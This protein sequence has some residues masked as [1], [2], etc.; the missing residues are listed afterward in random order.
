MY[1]LCL[2]YILANTFFFFGH[3]DIKTCIFVTHE[4]FHQDV[5]LDN[6]STLPYKLK[7]NLHVQTLS[8]SVCFA[9]TNAYDLYCS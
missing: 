4:L 9:N 7:S 2:L 5:L 6:L 8:S 3:Y 1:I